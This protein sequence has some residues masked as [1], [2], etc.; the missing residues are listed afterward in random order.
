MRANYGTLTILLGLVAVA[1][2]SYSHA[3]PQAIDTFQ[4]NPRRGAAE[5]SA[6]VNCHGRN[7]EG[8]FGPDLGCHRFGMDRL[9]KSCAPAVGHHACV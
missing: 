5:F 7:A 2:P 3:A 4:G 9:Q 8:G 6:C 1:T